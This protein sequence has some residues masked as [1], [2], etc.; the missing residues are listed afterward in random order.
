MIELKYRLC[1]ISANR[2]RIEALNAEIAK[3]PWYGFWE[4]RNLRERIKFNANLIEEQVYFIERER[5]M[6]NERKQA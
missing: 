5:R 3:T 4:K 1:L 6:E 2:K